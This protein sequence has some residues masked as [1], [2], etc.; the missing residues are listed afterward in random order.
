M[1]LK[2]IFSRIRVPATISFAHTKEILCI[3]SDFVLLPEVF[4]YRTC[5]A[6]HRLVNDFLNCLIT[7]CC[8]DVSLQEFFAACCTDVSLQEFSPLAALLCH[9]KTFLPAV[10]RSLASV[11][12]RHPARMPLVRALSNILNCF[13][14]VTS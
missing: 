7:A 10:L 5:L 3:N 13:V 9:R 6:S 4:W 2:F 14:K 12:F 1:H 8:T 11:L